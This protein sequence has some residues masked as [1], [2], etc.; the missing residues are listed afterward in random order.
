MN[1]DDPG[2][3]AKRVTE[4]T[5]VVALGSSFAAGPGITPIANRA[6]KRSADNAAQLVSR[7]LG[8]RLIDA[9]VSGATTAT[10]LHDSQRAGGRR[11]PP[12]IESVDENADLIL[13]TAAGNDLQYIGSLWSRSLANARTRNVL[14]RWIGERSIRRAPLVPPTA[15][16]LRRA[17]DGLSEIVVECRRRAPGAR[18]VLVDYLP[19]IDDDSAPGP[20]LPLSADEID[21]F[22]NVAQELAAVFAAAAKRTGAD[23]VPASAY[24][25]GHGAGSTDAYT[26]GWQVRANDGSHFHPTRAGMRAAASAI[27]GIL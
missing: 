10:I 9:S 15:D 25:T 20:I 17:T 1:S 24:G 11:F 27:L 8:A 26:L 22:R 3:A 18:V 19:V 6:A 5:T 7:T 14:T 13:V 16:Q 12:Q 4:Y 23:L 21:H 2:T